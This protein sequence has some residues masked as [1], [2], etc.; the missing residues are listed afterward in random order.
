MKIIS[1]NRF[2]VNRQQC[3]GTPDFPER[4]PPRW[5]RMADLRSALRHTFYGMYA[6]LTYFV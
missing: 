5:I 4:R 6:L 3:V 1:L 2:V